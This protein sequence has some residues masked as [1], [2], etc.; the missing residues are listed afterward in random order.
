M[1][2]TEE[3]EIINKAHKE[4]KAC[5]DSFEKINS[6][7]KKI[8][9]IASFDRMASRELIEKLPPYILRPSAS[10]FMLNNENTTRV[11]RIYEK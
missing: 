6:L 4:I 8:E 7:L 5:E 2:I 9:Y 11:R 10:Q 1:N 3:R